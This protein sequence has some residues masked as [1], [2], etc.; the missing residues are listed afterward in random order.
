[1]AIPIPTSMSF[2]EAASIPEAFLTAYQ[3][4][5]LYGQIGEVPF[6]EESSSNNNNN[7]RSKTVLIHA[8]AR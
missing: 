5:I 3:A 4:V 2:E 6:G 8:G 1:M 7:R